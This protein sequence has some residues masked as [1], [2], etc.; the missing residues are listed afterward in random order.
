MTGRP[1]RVRRIG[2]IALI[3]VLVVGAATVGYQRLTAGR[4]QVRY[5][6]RPVGYA[7]IAATVTETGTINPVNVVQVGSQVSGIIVGI[8]VDYNSRVHKGEVLATL[9]P[10]QFQAGAEQAGAN[11]SAAASQAAASQS[12]VAQAGDAV[13]SAAASL[14]Q[15]QANLQ[16]V[17]ANVTKVKAQLTLA[18]LTVQRD[19]SLL[20]QGFI[21]QSQLDI[22]RTTAEADAQD[23]QAA[24]AAVA[25]ARA[26]VN[27]ATA[28]VRSAQQQVHTAQAQAAASQ[29]QIAAQAAQVETAQY[30][31]SRTV[32]TSPIDG[33]VMARNVSVGQTV[34]A[35]FQTPTLFTIA[36]NLTDMQVDTSV[37]EADIG[38]VRPGDA[39]QITVTAYP[40]VVFSGTVQQV[41]VNPTIV[42]NV[43]TYDAVVIVHDASARLRPGMTA[44]VVIDVASRT[45][46]LAVPTAA[47]LYRPLAPRS[48]PRG[49]PPGGAS[50]GFPGA[51][52]STAAAPVAGAPGSRVTLWVLRGGRP[53]SVAVMIG[54]SDGRNVEITQGNLS[55]GDRV[56]IAQARGSSRGQGGRGQGSGGQG[57]G[58]PG[59][60]GA[61]GPGG[62]GGGGN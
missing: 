42:Q 48:T 15:A 28:Q 41:R 47:L 18:Q 57:A 20:Q 35:S 34:A 54:L 59:G 60:G 53:V 32:I 30:N 13:Q 45:H 51:S 40:N 56:I 46:V 10:V 33:I 29:H 2:V 38:N 62:G 21:A 61:G 58:G 17:Q 39:S 31:L 24:Q 7:D 1:A 14:Q 9:D 44:Q 8:N 4:N 36:S 3:A 22:D 43:V 19:T 5:I 37:D 12:A 11:L 50:F 25:V 6:T 55:E 23:Y 27:A 26:Q 16:N 49:T 52:P